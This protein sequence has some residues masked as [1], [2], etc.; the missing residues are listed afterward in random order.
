M[1]KQ[2]NIFVNSVFFTAGFSFVFALVGVA[3][4]SFLRTV[5]SSINEWAG[6]VGGVIIIFF[7]LY[8]MGLIKVSFLE[9]EHRLGF[10]KRF[11]YSYVTSFLFGAAFAIGWTPCIGAVL[12]AI[13]T[14]AVTNPFS[15]FWFLLAYS[16]GLGIPFLLTGAFTARASALISKAGRK[17]EYANR[18]SG[19]LLVIL[20]ILVFTNNLGRVANFSFVRNLLSGS[21][22]NLYFDP[23]SGTVLI[24]LG[25]SFLAGILSFLSPCIMPLVP[26][27]L[28]YMSSTA[29]N[30]T[31]K[32][33]EK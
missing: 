33:E 19:F 13:L 12:G 11:K 4:E 10:K 1:G 23:S 5:S 3:L 9:K 24:G 6:Y 27:Y 2:L 26:G 18:A 21:T 29:I 28:T 25:I 32:T 17:L 14:F 7:G 8:L 31:K 30:E 16:L 22:V 20:G 15:A